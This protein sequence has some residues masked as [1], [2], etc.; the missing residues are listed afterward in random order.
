M[1]LALAP[2]TLTL[3][4][5][6]ACGTK[7]PEPVDTAAPATTAVATTAIHTAV[8]AVAAPPTT[9]T[10]VTVEVDDS[11]DKKIRKARAKFFDKYEDLYA[12][13]AKTFPMDSTDEEQL[14]EDIRDACDL[15]ATNGQLPKEAAAMLTMF[16]GAQLVKTGHDVAGFLADTAALNRTIIDTGICG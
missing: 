11:A 14:Q 12:E 5:A 10:P 3:L 9:T 2:I 7:A 8:S 6:T 4:L 13:L 15:V 16:M 1:K